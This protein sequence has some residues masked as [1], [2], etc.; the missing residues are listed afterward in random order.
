MIQYFF[1]SNLISEEL[2]HNPQC[3]F[4][5]L[6]FYDG[7]C[8]WEEDSSTPV[9]HIGWVK[10]MVKSFMSFD[11][12]IRSKIGISKASVLNKEVDEEGNKILSFGEHQNLQ[13]VP[14]T[15]NNNYKKS[16][17]DISFGKF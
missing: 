14:D 15:V 10:P 2:L 17:D 8:S 5:L 6:Q 11:F 7:L 16:V 3:F 12:N 13:C 9:L 1:N 4:D